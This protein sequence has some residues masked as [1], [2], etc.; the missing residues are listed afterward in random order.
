M[1]AQAVPSLEEEAVSREPR[2]PVRRRLVAVLAVVGPPAVVFALTIAGWYAVTFLVL[3]PTRR[4]LLPAPHAV[5]LDG[6]LADGPR[7]QILRGLMLTARVSFMGLAIAFVIGSTMA[8]LMSQAKWIERSLYPYAVFMQTVPILA[9]VPLLGF[10]F[11]FGLAA[12]VVVSVIIS[13]FP[14]VINTLNGLLSAD[15]G[16]HDLLTLHR[17]GRVTRLFKLQ[18]PSGLPHVFTG[19]RT[20][21]GL[22]VIGAI[23]GDFF[24]GRGSPGLGML[25]ARY[26]SR[27]QSEALFAAVLVS[28]LLGLAVFAAFGWLNQRAVGH[29]SEPQRHPGAS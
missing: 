14:L 18:I 17:T 2:R 1:T 23:V 25:L 20:A 8:L 11:G 22:A 16:L 28:C 10:W 26:A 13:L 29:W 19:L 27:L 15:R 4:F 6:L 21:A 9:L 12:R 3:D 24:F 7:Q 5:I